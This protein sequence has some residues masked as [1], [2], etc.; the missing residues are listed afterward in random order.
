[1]SN[2]IRNLRVVGV[3]A[4]FAA[5]I[6]VAAGCASTGSAPA[7]V[8]GGT[9]VWAEQ[10]GLEPNWIWPFTPFANYIPSN[11]QDFQW[12][13]YRQLYTFGN[14]GNSISVNYPLSL[15]KPATYSDGGKTVTITMKGWK[16]SNGET[17]GARDVVFWL[18]MLKAEKINYAGYEPGAMPDNLVSDTA[19]GPDQVTLRLDK[20]YSS[21]WI[22][23]NQLSDIIPMPMAWDVTSLGAKPGSGGCAT[24][25]AADHWAKCKAVYTFLTGQAKDTGTYATSPIWGVVDG[26]WKLSAFN[27]NGNVTFVP[28]AKYSGSPKPRISAFKEVPFTSDSAQYTALKTGQVNVGWIPSADL[29]QK[30]PTSAMP[31]SN[32]LG[33]SYRLVPFYNYMISFWVPN[34]NNPSAGWIFR[35]LYVRQALQEVM[36]QPGIIKAV[37]RG[38]GSPTSG[39]APNEPAGNQW[40]PATQK[41]NG[42]QGPYPFSVVRARALLTSH[43]WSEEGGVMTCQ[44]PAKCGAHISKGQQLRFSIY[45]AGGLD[46]S[47]QVFQVYKSDAS[48]AGIAVNPVAQSYNTVSGEGVPCN[49]GPQCNWQGVWYAGWAFNGPNWLP[50]GEPMFETGAEGNAGSYSNGTAD[51]VIGLVETSNNV[52]AYHEYAAFMAGQLPVIWYPT[53]TTIDAVSSDLHNV[54]FNPFWTLLPEYWYFTK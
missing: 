35:Q 41:E 53:S 19:T 20:P 31:P 44:V 30:G 15:A 45:Y 28:N 26:P 12:L 34:F 25:T 23:Y 50:T 3:A 42:N 49:M 37:Y 2:H 46:G 38:Y 14:N 33:G 11:S 10:P 17:V 27:T 29:P 52:T 1:M 48:R 22:T 36:D 18:N 32:P 54:T 8:H 7:A 21:T 51:K 4:A 5:A 16:W 13:M 9:A 43:G 40:I 39:A 47:D 24:D 6:L